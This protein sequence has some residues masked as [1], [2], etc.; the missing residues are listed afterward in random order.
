MSF[1]DKVNEITERAGVAIIN[2]CANKFWDRYLDVRMAREDTRTAW[3]M[4]MDGYS[5]R[6]SYERALEQEGLVRGGH[7]HAQALDETYFRRPGRRS[8]VRGFLTKEESEQY[9]GRY[10]DDL[11][12]TWSRG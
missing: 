10:R 11:D 9:Y 2:A 7:T 12:N 4:Y 1:V 8:K 6:M 3:G 5:S